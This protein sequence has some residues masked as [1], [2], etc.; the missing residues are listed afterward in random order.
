[1]EKAK[2]NISVESSP[3]SLMLLN[4]SDDFSE[5]NNDCA[6]FCNAFLALAEQLYKEDDP[7]L[8]GMQQQ[9]L[10]MKAQLQHFSF[11]LQDAYLLVSEVQRIQNDKQKKTC[12]DES[13]RG[14]H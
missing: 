8:Y 12:E 10:A 4:L 3:L 6:F 2:E 5:F 14:L 13:G 7:A 11:R 1:M 9:A